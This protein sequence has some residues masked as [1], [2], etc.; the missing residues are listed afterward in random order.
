KEAPMEINNETTSTESTTSGIQEGAQ[1]SGTG[2]STEQASGEGVQGTQA[3]GAGNDG[4]VSQGTGAQAGTSDATQAWK[5]SFKFK[6]K[7]KE[8]EFDDFV[9]PIIK[10]KDLEQKF[11]DLYEKA[12]GLDEVKTSREAFKQQVEEWKGKYNQV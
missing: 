7:D 12:H 8:L 2:T 10:T 4:A 11:K 3:A 5:P 1:S 6:V 9:K